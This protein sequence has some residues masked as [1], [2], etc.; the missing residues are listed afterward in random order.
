[1]RFSK[2]QDLAALG[3]LLATLGALVSTAAGWWSEIYCFLLD[4]QTL[5][6]GILAIIAAAW[7]VREMRR[8][9]DAGQAER[10]REA[11]FR[12]RQATLNVHEVVY[13]FWREVQVHMDEL[14]EISVDEF[15]PA[16]AYNTMA[17]AANTAGKIIT[18]LMQS[19]SIALYHDSGIDFTWTIKHATNAGAYM[20]KVRDRGSPLIQTT[21]TQIEPQPQITEDDLEAFCNDFRALEYS[22]KDCIWRAMEIADARI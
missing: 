14:E 15:I 22:L 17:N 13:P 4:W 8:S 12:K 19:P 3:V 11:L 9:F 21:V 6:T 10:Q 16:L 1:M 7:T 20:K 2:W 5:M 18:A